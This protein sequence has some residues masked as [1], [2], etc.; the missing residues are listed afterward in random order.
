MDGRPICELRF[1]E[2]L[3]VVGESDSGKSTSAIRETT[4]R[5]WL[6]KMSAFPRTLLSS[7]GPSTYACTVTSR[8]VVASSAIRMRGSTVWS[9]TLAPARSCKRG[10]YGPDGNIN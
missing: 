7:S 10:H 4:A 3:G 9:R 5:S 1:G 6:M 8:A 2:T